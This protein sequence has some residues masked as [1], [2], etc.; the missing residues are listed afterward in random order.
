MD[1]PGC[2][3]P[4]SAKQK[5]CRSCGFGLE[6][7]SALVAERAE[8]SP[9]SRAEVDLE[10]RLSPRKVEKLAGAIFY[11]GL[12]AA[13]GIGFPAAIYLQY[14]QGNLIASLMLSLLFLT[15]ASGATLFWIAF[16]R[17]NAK[18]HRAQQKKIAPQSL[19]TAELAAA[20]PPELMPSI[21]EH[22]TELLEPRPAKVVE[23]DRS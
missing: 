23:R 13:I 1:C 21:A 16:L 5:F 10:Q 4:A 8:E 9:S 12:T 14:H 3:A 15:L 6:Q 20:S 7:V 19:T 18:E 2:G 22:T 11:G 17:K